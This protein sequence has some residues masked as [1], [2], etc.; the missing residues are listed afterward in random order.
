MSGKLTPFEKRA[1]LVLSEKPDY[2][3]Y[4]Y[5]RLFPDGRFNHDRDVGSAG[6]GPS[7]SECAVN[8]HLGR[9]RIKGLA[10]QEYTNGPGARRWKTTSYGR[11]MLRLTGG[12]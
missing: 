7:R 10:E 2:P 3:C 4:L 9:L 12:G 6:G 5:K 1:L 8:W 11:E